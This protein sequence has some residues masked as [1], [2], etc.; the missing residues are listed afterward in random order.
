LSTRGTRL[1]S[2]TRRRWLLL[3]GGALSLA[4]AAAAG[5]WFV[6]LPA[7]RPGL[8]EGERYGIDV[9][10]HQ[11][12]IDWSRVA[13]DD[14]S[15]A[16]IKATEGGDFVDG[17]FA[18]NWLNSKL[19]GLSQ[20]AYHFFTLCTPGEQ[21]ARN[22]LRVV[23][24]E[25]AALPPAVDLE[26]AGNCSA[27]PDMTTVEH[28][29]SAFLRLV[30]EATGRTAILYVGDDFE[31]RYGVRGAFGRP[32]WHRRFLRRPNVEGWVMWQVSGLAEVDGVTGRVD[33]NVL[34][35]AEP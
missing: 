1:H 21:Q 24:N 27:R 14:I 10:H 5:I 15:F 22:F 26:L 30:E 8:R 18:E 12:A 6:W 17:R 23:P 7:Y 28:E 2:P 20:G 29:L 33:L 13:D 4:L 9:S 32:L 3:A 31:E 19:V 25:P 35:P 34:R 16:Y 11:G